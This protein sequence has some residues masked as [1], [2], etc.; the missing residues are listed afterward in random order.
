M[1]HRCQPLLIVVITV[2]IINMIICCKRNPGICRAWETLSWV[3]PLGCYV[4]I[5]PLGQPRLGQG[6]VPSSSSHRLI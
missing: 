1:L 5:I 3:S 2:V 4:P 6:D